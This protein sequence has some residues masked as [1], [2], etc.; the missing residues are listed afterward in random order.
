MAIPRAVLVFFFLAG[1]LVPSAAYSAD[2]A[3][4]AKVSEAKTETTVKVKSEL[5]K[6]E[7]IER[8]QKNL[9]SFNEIVGLVPGLKKET[10][11]KGKVSYTY[12]GSKLEDLSKEQLAKVYSRVNNEA[13]RLR[14]DRLNKQLATIR[15][16]E[17][18]TKQTRQSNPVYK[19]PTKPYQ[20]PKIPKTK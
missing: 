4:A 8:I 3:K 20:P 6:P 2:T 9:D 7:M 18:I 15:R 5:T 16:A 10:D 12:Q 14:T 19:A 13:V 17:Q 11:A 1:F